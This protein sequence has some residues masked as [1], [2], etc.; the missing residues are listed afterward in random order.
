MIVRLIFRCV[1]LCFNLFKLCLELL[2]LR[3]H[4]QDLL[5]LQGYDITKLEMPNMGLTYNEINQ[6]AGASL[7]LL[8]PGWS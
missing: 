1:E 8:Q 6:V 5:C 3:T 2:G 4:C 7:K